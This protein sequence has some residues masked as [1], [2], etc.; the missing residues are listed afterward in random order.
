MILT[1]LLDGESLFLEVK[2]FDTPAT[3]TIFVYME[4]SVLTEEHIAVSREAIY[5]K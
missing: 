3:R 5:V 1:D 4:K 2:A